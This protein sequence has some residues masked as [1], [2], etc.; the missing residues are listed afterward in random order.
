MFIP[1][2]PTPSPTVARRHAP[3]AGR[4]RLCAVH[5]SGDD[6]DGERCHAGVLADALRASTL[7][8][9]AASLVACSA[10][11]AAAAAGGA[12]VT[13]PEQLP[14][15]PQ[16]DLFNRSYAGSPA[17]PAS[18]HAP[19]WFG[20][21][22]DAPVVRRSMLGASVIAGPQ[23]DRRGHDDFDRGGG[24]Y[25]DDD[26][27]DAGAGLRNPYNA[28]DASPTAAA[29]P[30][31]AHWEGARSSES[32]A[33]TMLLVENRSDTMQVEVRWID[34]EGHEVLAAVLA[35][36]SSR[37]Q[38]TYAAHPWVLREHGS[39]TSILMFVAQNALGTAIVGADG[40][41]RYDIM[42]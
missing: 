32:A 17:P 22:N 35:P 27:D 8:A 42:I 25:D 5:G 28:P 30:I 19:D 16:M 13:S 40:S 38:P 36:G 10:W 11:P 9:V 39:Q 34:F 33:P 6:G 37:F 4:L 21:R 14:H 29:P 23:S 2:L 31:S 7:G 15:P 26:K 1:T 3:R 20:G 18:A 41:A 12:P 24:G